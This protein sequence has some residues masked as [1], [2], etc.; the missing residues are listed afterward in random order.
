MSIL[1][2][3][4]IF[5]YGEKRPWLLELRSSTTFIVLTVCTAVFTVSN[6][7]SILVGYLFC[8][9]YREYQTAMN[10]QHDLSSVNS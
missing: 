3:F 8:T 1:Q 6:Y 5:G 10:Q 9:N 2:N 7:L 4:M